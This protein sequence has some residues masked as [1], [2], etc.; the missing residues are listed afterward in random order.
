M[1]RTL[2]SPYNIQRIFM[3]VFRKGSVHLKSWKAMICHF[4]FLNWR[5]HLHLRLLDFLCMENLFGNAEVQFKVVRFDNIILSHLV[6]SIC[7]CKV[8]WEVSIC[9]HHF[10]IISSINFWCLD[11]LCWLW[12]LIFRIRPFHF[13]ELYKFFTNSLE[14]LCSSTRNRWSRISSPRKS[15]FLKLHPQITKFQIHE[16]CCGPHLKCTF[17]YDYNT[18]EFV[19]ACCCP[20][21]VWNHILTLCSKFFSIFS[22]IETVWSVSYYNDPNS[23]LFCY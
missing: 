2:I 3:L 11:F 22:S 16:S 21:H 12:L 19:L 9:C 10:I 15:C 23:F 18:R 20:M 8:R 14:K 1:G 5:I 17:G 13:I 4:H 6:S 7:S